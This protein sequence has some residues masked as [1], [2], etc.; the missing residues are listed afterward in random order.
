MLSSHQFIQPFYLRCSRSTLARCPPGSNLH[1][2]LAAAAAAAA[3]TAAA[4][5]RPVTLGLLALVRVSHLSFAHASRFISLSLAWHTTHLCIH[6]VP[7][8]LA[9]NFG[10][11]L[12]TAFDRAFSR[13]SGIGAS[14]SRQFVALLLCARSKSRH[15]HTWTLAPCEHLTAY[16][17]P[18]CPLSIPTLRPPSLRAQTT[19]RIGALAS[20]FS[21]HL[22]APPA[23]SMLPRLASPPRHSRPTPSI[24]PPLLA[25][26]FSHLAASLQIPFVVFDVSLPPTRS[27][28]LRLL[29]RKTLVSLS[30]RTRAT[31]LRTRTPPSPSTPLT[32]SVLLPQRLQTLYVWLLRLG[33]AP[34]PNLPFIDQNAQSRPASRFFP[35]AWAYSPETAVLIPRQLQTF[36]IDTAKALPYPAQTSISQHQR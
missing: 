14:S 2:V 3:A 13:A 26:A 7:A 8:L 36:V 33:L 29:P 20:T 4:A 27:A 30:T 32:L 22:P 21:A 19:L 28:S 1:A 23:A 31:T 16:L 18:S 9:C 12:Q 17:A 5:L 11:H 6:D 25:L 10:P 34:P 15:I 35:P 24:P